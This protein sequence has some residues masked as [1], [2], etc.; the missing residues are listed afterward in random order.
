M[1]AGAEHG[2]GAEHERAESG[3]QPDSDAG[4]TG[5]PGHWMMIACCVPM[6]VIAIVLVASGASIGTLVIAVACT[7]MMA[8]MMVGMTRGG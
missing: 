6:L 4:A 7:A 8:A 3:A 5:G 2:P 1:S